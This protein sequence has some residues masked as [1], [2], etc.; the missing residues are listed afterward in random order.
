MGEVFDACIIGSGAAGG[1]A[2]H[3][4]SS[5]GLR[6][7]VLEAGPDVDPQVDFKQHQWPYEFAAR[8]LG[9]AGEHDGLMAANGFWSIRGEPYTCKPGTRFL[10]FRSRIVG[11]RTNHW[12]Q[13]AVRFDPNDFLSDDDGVR[14]PLSYED[15]APYYDKVEQ[16]IGVYGSPNCD[17][18]LP[19]PA[20]RCTELMIQAASATIGLPCDVAPGS[21]LTR[22]HRG[23]QACH[24]CGQCWR[25]CR[26][27]SNYSSSL[28]HIRPA[29]ATGRVTMI[30]NAV[31]REID[32]APDGRADGVI[33]IDKIT[34]AHHR[35]RA[36]A[37][38]VAAGACESARLLLNSRSNLWPNGMG[39]SS[40]QVGQNLRDS[41]ASRGE[42]HFPSLEA[43]PP[44]NH[45]GVGRPH[46]WIPKGKLREDATLAR[47]NFHIFFVGG[48]NMPLLGEFQ[49]ILSVTDGYGIELKKTCRRT[50]GA[51]MRFTAVGE[52]VSN[53]SNCTIDT[54]AADEWGIPVLRFDFHWGADDYQLAQ[55]MQNSIA[56]LVDA[57]GGTYLTTVESTGKRAFGIAEGGQGFHEQ[58]TAR[59]GR[60]ARRSVLNSFCQLH[61]V[62]NVFVADAAGFVSSS[63]KPPTL[64]IMALAWRAS[65]FLIDEMRRGDL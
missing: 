9:A 12:G 24:F 54:A 16:D 25:G 20:P 44:H 63:D 13:G 61:D 4:L 50:Y 18:S 19:A 15:V 11:G 65:E 64:T 41:V 49:E 46:L 48:R 33:Y 26:D 1:V 52:M 58:G 29:I 5:A 36:R 22:S 7:C 27:R 57:A 21:I 10:W 59:M 23:R 34:R 43:I 32:V 60:D 37:I 8:G 40:G 39:N 28:V 30:T 47:K 14:W 42:A 17:H 51:V 6:L 35:V 56:A 31:A 45:D 38:I 55:S 3:V 2:T 62:N 53:S